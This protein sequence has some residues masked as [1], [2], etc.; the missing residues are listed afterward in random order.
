M[1]TGSTRSLVVN[2]YKS[3]HRVV[4]Q[5]FQGDPDTIRAAKSRVK[6]EYVKNLNETDPS[7][8]RELLKTAEDVEKV[9]QTDVIRAVKNEKGHYE[10]Q[11]KPH[12]LQDNAT[13][14]TKETKDQ[15]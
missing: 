5:V 12:H 3:L 13:C 9:L 10:V 7:K 11:L 6:E 2:S 15:R 14:S 4:L 1:S 8:I